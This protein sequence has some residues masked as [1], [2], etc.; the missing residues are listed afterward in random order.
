LCLGALGK[1]R[2]QSTDSEVEC[3]VRSTTQPAGVC[4]KFEVVLEKT[5]WRWIDSAGN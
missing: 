1:S 2:Q 5:M 3:G 4:K